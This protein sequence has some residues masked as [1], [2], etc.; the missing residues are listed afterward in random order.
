MLPLILIVPAVLTSLL[1]GGGSQQPV[2]GIGQATASPSARESFGSLPVALATPSGSVEAWATPT[3]S[4]RAT[5]TPTARATPKPTAKPKSP[6]PKPPPPVGTAGYGAG[7]RGGAGGRL[8]AVTN[9]NDSGAGSLRAAMAANG[10]RTVV[11]RVGGLLSLKSDLVIK[12]PYI[13]VDG[14]TAPQGG[15]V[16][17]DGMLKVLSHDVIVRDLRLRPS[18]QV[19]QPADDDAVT[20]NGLSG[21]VYNVVLDHL[22]MLWGPDIGGLSILGNVHDVTVQYSIMGE[23][24]YLSRHPEAVASQSGHSMAASV[25]QLDPNVHW[26]ER[27]TFHHNLFTTSDQRMPVVQGAECVDLVNNVIY[28]WGNKGLHGNPR[29]MNVV[30]NWFRSGPETTRKLVYEWQH[31][32]ANPNPYPASVYLSGNAADGFAYEVEAPAGVIRKSL[33]CGSLSVRASA[34]KTAYAVVLGSVGVTRP[35]RDVVDQ[36]IIGNV[37]GRRGTFFN[38]AGYPAPNPYYP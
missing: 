12:S 18:D 32:S 2:A 8:I 3:R 26:P 5:P 24:L 37:Q 13:T 6:A 19:A 25:F 34:A 38:G 23:G 28:N 35:N 7:T 22:T 11:F 10:P 33:A 31:H 15:V 16:I 9:L 21:E 30:G 27:I 20:L 29:A 36:R 1:M 17:R 14:S 4:P